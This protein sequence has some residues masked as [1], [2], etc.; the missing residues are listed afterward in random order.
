MCATLRFRAL[1]LGL[2]L[3]LVACGFAPLFAQTL[4]DVAKKEEDRRKTIKDPAKVL[5]NKD[6]KPAPLPSAPPADLSDKS[7]DQT[8]E[9]SADDKAQ[10]EKSA[11]GQKKDKS[12]APKERDQSYWAGRMRDLLTQ[13]DRDQ[14][15]ADALQTKVNAL[16]TDFV[17]RDDPKQR[18]EIGRERQ[19]ALDELDRLKKA[20]PDDKKAISDL[21]E[22]ARRAG[23]PPGWLRS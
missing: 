20:I 12:A 19:R 5:T 17:N 13:L 1:T 14:S 22:E 21:E 18:E 15:Y 6:L 10:D 23:V 4:G 7:D 2:A 8:A 16:T 11:K 3:G 9:T